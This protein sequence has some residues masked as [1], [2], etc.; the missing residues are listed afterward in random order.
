MQMLKSRRR[1]GY[2]VFM[3][4][5]FSRNGIGTVANRDFIEILKRNKIKIKK[6]GILMPQ[7]LNQENAGHPPILFLEPVLKQN[8]WGGSR[9]GTEFGYAIPS[10][11]TGECWG[12]STHPNGDCTVKEGAFAGKK[13]SVLWNE[14]RGLFGNL[15]MEQFPLLVKII[16]AKDDLSIQVHPDDAYAAAHENGSLGKT[17]CWYIMD[18]PK[19]AELVVGHHAR[20]KEELSDL[21]YGGKWDA[22]IRRIPIQKGDFIQIDPGTVHAITAG[23]LLLE[24]QQSS[25]VTYRVYDYGRLMDGKP[26]QLHVAQSLDVI[27]VPAKRVQDSVMHTASLAENEWQELISCP[28]YRVYKLNVNGIYYFEQSWAFLNLTVIE[29]GGMINGHALAKGDHLIL[30]FGYGGVKLQGQME[31]VASAP[32]W[33]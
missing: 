24:T 25:D 23:C 11:H 13:L 2:A 17:E 29:G 3:L 7:V 10:G 21:I 15:P 14:Q 32:G 33:D 9:L 6:E 31:V 8:I 22:F 4:R 16:D 27:T 28:Y 20:S 1:A 12:I 30:P 19:D 26:R 5:P 18:C